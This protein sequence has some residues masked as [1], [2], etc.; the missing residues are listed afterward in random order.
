MAQNPDMVIGPWELL[1]NEVLKHGG[2]K[3]DLEVKLFG[4]GKV[5]EQ[6]NG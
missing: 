5:L 2:N 1:I 3:K 6:L 4:G